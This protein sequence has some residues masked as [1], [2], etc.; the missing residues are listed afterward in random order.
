M[1]VML[2]AM[3]DD[4]A[5]VQPVYFQMSC[6]I[7]DA[8]RRI[9]ALRHL[10]Q[11]LHF[12]SVS[13]MFV[14]K[15]DDCAI[16]EDDPLEEIKIRSRAC[17]KIGDCYVSIQPERM[18]GFVAEMPNKEIFCIGLCVYPAKIKID[19]SL[20]ETGLGGKAYWANFV[21][22][23]VFDHSR[24]ENLEECVRSHRSVNRILKQAE[25]D[26][27]L[28]K[29]VDPTLFWELENLA[30]LKSTIHSSARCH[31]SLADT[32]VH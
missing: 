17:L 4:S 6:K 19:D 21:S 24:E 29:V 14:F 25:Q 12:N 9:K 5:P 7:E 20:I 10:A 31:A 15:G 28:D 22:T 16:L 27:I 26:G 18:V 2:A 11:D 32:S 3:E 30:L 8:T 23:V 1:T 13:S